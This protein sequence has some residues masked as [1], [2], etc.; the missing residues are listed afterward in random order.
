MSLS[1][2]QRKFLKSLAHPMKPVVM[3]GDKGL[4][5]NVLGEIELALGHH[6]LIKVKVSGADRD[7][8]DATIQEICTKT[9][10][11]LVTRIGN[12]AVL[13]RERPANFKAGK[14]TQLYSLKLPK[15]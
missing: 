2:Q 4:T 6:E 1:N 9:N 5:E 12:V 11:E 8:R 7:D 3:L 10:A 13:Y 15:A 14:N